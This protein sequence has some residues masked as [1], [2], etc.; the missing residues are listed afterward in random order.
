MQPDVKVDSSEASE[1]ID[2]TGLSE[3]GSWDKL[4][5]FRQFRHWKI[6]QLTFRMKE[7][8]F[9]LIVATQLVK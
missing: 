3:V 1:A 6:K 7:S 2:P 5:K 4:V 8:R 9:Y